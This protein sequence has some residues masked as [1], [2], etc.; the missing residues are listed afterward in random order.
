MDFVRG[1]F[2][3][4]KN[5]GEGH[6][7]SYQEAYDYDVD[8]ETLYLAML[9]PNIHNYDIASCK[10]LSDFLLE[11]NFSI[12]D[13]FNMLRSQDIDNIFW[14]AIDKR[15]E[16]ARN[17][18]SY[19]KDREVRNRIQSVM[20]PMIKDY[21]IIKKLTQGSTHVMNNYQSYEEYPTL[22]ITTGNKDIYGL[23]LSGS[24]TTITYL[25]KE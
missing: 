24:L 17:K 21:V 20:P 3:E 22:S 5:I 10:K 19:S 2:G 8:I 9:C 11:C 18:A 4:M 25:R 7:S 16:E 6:I 13:A 14:E 12:E 1:I 23:E 15:L